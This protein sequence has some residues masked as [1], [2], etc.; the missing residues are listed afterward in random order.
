MF[1]GVENSLLFNKPDVKREKEPRT[2][3]F[4]KEMENN[5]QERVCGDLCVFVLMVISM[6]VCK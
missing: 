5:I 2:I 3:S 6:C 1:P 4:Y